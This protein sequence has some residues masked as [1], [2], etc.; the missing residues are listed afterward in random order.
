LGVSRT[1]RLLAGE[2][3][4]QLLPT[5]TMRLI[6]AG[7]RTITSEAIVREAFAWSLFDWAEIALVIS[8]AAS[9]VDIIGEK[10]ALNK[11][12][13]V[14]CFPAAWEDFGRA[15]GPIRNAEMV[16]HADA[17]LAVWDGESRGTRDII[18]KALDADL[19]VYVHRV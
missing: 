8:G 12:V 2:R 4:G 6:I 11:G 9:G 17:L 15:A 18:R 3:E 1:A 14:H 19:F 10:I 13:R 7:T 16:R 5:S